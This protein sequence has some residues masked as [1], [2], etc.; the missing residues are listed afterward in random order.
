MK[1]IAYVFV[2]LVLS[3]VLSIFGAFLT[4]V[5][6]IKYLDEISLSDLIYFGILYVFVMSFFIMFMPK[7][8][9]KSVSGYSISRLR[10]QGIVYI[11]KGSLGLPNTAYII[12]SNGKHNIADELVGLHNRN[13][14]IQIWLPQD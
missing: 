9:K 2:T 11:Q 10:L 4:D 8:K 12:D 14:T 1:K 7:F 13:A 3:F 6:I 5:Y